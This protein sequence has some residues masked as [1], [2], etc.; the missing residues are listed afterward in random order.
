[1]HQSEPCLPVSDTS[2]QAG[3]ALCGRDTGH[4]SS[5]YK[6]VF[7]EPHCDEIP[8]LVGDLPR[9]MS[10]AEACFWFSVSNVVTIGFGQVVS[11][12][13][14][15]PWQLADTKKVQTV[16]EFGKPGLVGSPIKPDANRLVRQPESE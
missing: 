13:F 9:N 7:C 11:T 15:L 5:C 8:H 1:M 3:T 12:L 2:H 14:L 6:Q 10:L 16:S 4:Y